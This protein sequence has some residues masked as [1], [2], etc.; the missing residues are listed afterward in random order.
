MW[1]GPKYLLNKFA[2]NLGM[3]VGGADGVIEERRLKGFG[4]GRKVKEGSD[5]DYQGEDRT[6][7]LGGNMKHSSWEP[8]YRLGPTA[9]SS[10]KPGGFALS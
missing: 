10:Q 8:S 2:D 4:L 1:F 7:V 9:L 6:T 3:Y 5:T